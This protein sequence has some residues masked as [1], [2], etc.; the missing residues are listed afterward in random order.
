MHFSQHWRLLLQHHAFEH[1][2]A[3]FKLI[4][5][6][7]CDLASW[8]FQH[9]LVVALHTNTYSLPWKHFCKCTCT[10]RETTTNRYTEVTCSQ[11]LVY[12]CQIQPALRKAKG[13]YLCH[14]VL[15]LRK[16]HS[17]T[18]QITAMYPY[19]QLA[20]HACHTLKNIDMLFHHQVQPIKV[21]HEYIVI[22]SPE[23]ENLNE[24]FWF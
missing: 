7:G 23:F 10:H 3:H 17:Q 9:F 2:R 19:L 5:H 4:S 1:S 13:E 15:L 18:G 24:L 21:N 11:T 14:V 20:C 8:G 16:Q 6:P 22:I 12:E